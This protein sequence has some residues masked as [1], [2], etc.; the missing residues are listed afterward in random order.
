LDKLAS[1]KP[2]GMM[3]EREG[4]HRLTDMSWVYGWKRE[5]HKEG[6]LHE[7]EWM[8]QIEERMHGWMSLRVWLA[9]VE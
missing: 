6:K 4:W 5:R 3:R 2:K 9:V 1:Y 7:N 8:K